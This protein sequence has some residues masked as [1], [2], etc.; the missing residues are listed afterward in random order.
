MSRPVAVAA[1]VTAAVLAAVPAA[2]QAPPSTILFTEVNKGSTFKFVDTPPRITKRR[3]PSTGDQLVFTTPLVKGAGGAHGTLRATCTIT[4]R[5]QKATPAL[6]YGVF[7][8]AEGQL[9]AVLSI[10]NLDAKK[11]TG[12]IVGGTRAYAGA[13]GTLI[14]TQTKTGSSDAI[15]L[16]P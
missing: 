6:C 10:A 5:G 12:A 4:G 11:T 14:S 2:A 13:R 9:V 16:M 15:T 7:T 3:G 1:A 8:F